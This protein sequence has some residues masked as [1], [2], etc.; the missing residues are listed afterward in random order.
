MTAEAVRDCL[1]PYSTS[2]P[3]GLGFGLPLAK[4]IVEADHRGSLSIRSRPG[5]G[6]TITVSLPLAQ[7]R[8]EE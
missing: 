5:E 3:A 4:K 6:T 1:L 8:D 2:K 7:P